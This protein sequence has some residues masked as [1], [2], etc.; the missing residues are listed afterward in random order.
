MCGRCSDHFVPNKQIKSADI[1]LM[2]LSLQKERR[3]KQTPVRVIILRWR[4]SLKHF[5]TGPFYFLGNVKSLC[6]L[7]SVKREAGEGMTGE[8]MTVYGRSFTEVP[9]QVTKRIKKRKLGCV[10]LTYLKWIHSH[11]E[12]QRFQKIHWIILVKTD[13]LLYCSGNYFGSNR[14][15]YSS[16]QF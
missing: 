10:V 5:K 12:D 2:G 9:Q 6:L 3:R 1:A 11:S 4:I 13:S 14:T 8:G 15:L 16:L 7:S